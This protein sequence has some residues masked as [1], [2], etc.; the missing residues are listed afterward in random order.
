MTKKD[1]TKD[2]ISI[3]LELTTEGRQLF[4]RLKQTCG[5]DTD[6]ELIE[7]VLD[8]YDVAIEQASLQRRLAFVDDRIPATFIVAMPSLMHVARQN[9]RRMR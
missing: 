9:K 1:G 6:A 5:I 4:D 8:F 7:L 3:T 2:T